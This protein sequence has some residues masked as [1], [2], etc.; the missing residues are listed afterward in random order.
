MQTDALTHALRWNAAILRFIEP[1]HELLIYYDAAY[2][3]ACIPQELGRRFLTQFNPNGTLC[4]DAMRAAYVR[5]LVGAIERSNQINHA[6]AERATQEL[7]ARLTKH[8]P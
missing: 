5:A 4:K 7:F 3:G 1:D 8:K 2:S 6:E